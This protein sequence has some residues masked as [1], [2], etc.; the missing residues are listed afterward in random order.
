MITEEQ[1]KRL[2]WWMENH[3]NKPFYVFMDEQERVLDSDWLDS[4]L[5]ALQ[6]AQALECRVVN[7]LRWVAWSDHDQEDYGIVPHA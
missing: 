2:L 3:L 5:E 4:D 7:V 6:H 1:Q